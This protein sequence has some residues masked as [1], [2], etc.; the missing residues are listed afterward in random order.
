MDEAITPHV[1]RA[2]GRRACSAMISLPVWA[3]CL[4]ALAVVLSPD[5]AFLTAMAVEI[6]IGALVD[7]GTLPVF[8]LVSAGAIGWFSLRKAWVR[9]RGRARVEI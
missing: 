6:V 4:I 3:I 5:L 7:A 8:S 2:S 9:R 1:R